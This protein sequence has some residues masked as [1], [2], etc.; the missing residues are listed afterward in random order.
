MIFSTVV[1]DGFL[2]SIN[3]SSSMTWLPLP[4]LFFG[5]GV[6]ENTAK[7]EFFLPIGDNGSSHGLCPSGEL[8]VKINEAQ[9]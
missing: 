3:W 4:S 7:P 1:L 8:I 6:T 2:S 9:L 5:L